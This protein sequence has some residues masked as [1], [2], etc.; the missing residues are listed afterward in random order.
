[1]RARVIEVTGYVPAIMSLYMTGKNV[2]EE[3][4]NDIRYHVEQSIDRWGRVVNPT[5]EFNNYMDKVI[6][7]GVKY[8][9]ETILDF[10]KIVVFMEGIHRGA[11]DCF[12]N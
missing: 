6:K 3:R 5:N 11:Q 4:L 9:H 8:E 10:I 7:Y 1:M 2:D 12:L